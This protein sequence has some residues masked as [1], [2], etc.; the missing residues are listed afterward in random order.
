MLGMAIAAGMAAP[1]WL[2]F[3]LRWHIGEGNVG[4]EALVVGV[5]TAAFFVIFGVVEWSNWREDARDRHGH[6]SCCG[7]R[8]RG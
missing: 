7:C 8:G 4:E 1:L 2:M 6:C 3:A 5:I